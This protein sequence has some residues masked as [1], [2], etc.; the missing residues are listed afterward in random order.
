[1]PSTTA[2]FRTLLPP[3]DW[4]QLAPTVQRMHAEGR[5]VQASGEA[6][7][8]G[9]THLPARLLRRLLTLPEPG[10]GQAITVTIERH[11]TH[12]RW[13]RHFLR[14]Q[15]HSTLR[16]G[17]D[18]QLHERLGPVTLHF[19]LHRDG[20]AIEWQLQG[21][22]LLGM[23]LPRALCGTVLSRSG[24]RDGRY[25]FDIDTRLPGIGRLIAYRGWLEI[26]HVA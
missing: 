4:P 22:R 21:V 25:A 6:D 26:D 11:P 20:D 16:A 13:S 14:S 15:M 24:M 19:A 10:A 9:E 3:A 23:P 18:G 1:M 7:V 2:L 5:I 8:A 17:H 12:E